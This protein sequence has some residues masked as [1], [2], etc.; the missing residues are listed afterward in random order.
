MEFT[1]IFFNFSSYCLLQFWPLEQF[2]KDIWKTSTSSCLKLGQLIG[3][4]E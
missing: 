3:D 1:G 4:D 2:N